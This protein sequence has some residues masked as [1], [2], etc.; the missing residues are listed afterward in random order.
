MKLKMYTFSLLVSLS[1]TVGI[2]NA[3]PFS[4][5][6]ADI[7]VTLDF[8]TALQLEISVSDHGTITD[9]DTLLDISNSGNV[10]SETIK[11]SH[12]G[13]TIT[14]IDQRDA[15]GGI[16]VFGDEMPGREPAVG[17][18]SVFDGMDINGVWTLTL[19]STGY[20]YGNINEWTIMSDMIPSQVPVP[21]AL[22]L[23]GS[24]L[25]GFIGLR[26]KVSKSA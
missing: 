1:L 19:V 16:Y 4:Y 17:T 6:S 22:W 5:S 10:F 11:L 12:G 23:F 2:A 25:L 3:A 9:I 15:P 20:T 14:L 13:Q 26:K 21:A 24:A 18:L 7:P 8:D